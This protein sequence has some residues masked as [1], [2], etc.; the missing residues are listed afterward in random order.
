M[1]ASSFMEAPKKQIP[2]RTNRIHAQ[3][4]ERSPEESPWVGWAWGQGGGHQSHPGPGAAMEEAGAGLAKGG[5]R[6]PP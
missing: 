1:K 2:D 5:P 3:C 6:R 4:G